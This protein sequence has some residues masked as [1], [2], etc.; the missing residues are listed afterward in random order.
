MSE[1]R[2]VNVVDQL[3]A[4]I[5]YTRAEAER[6]MADADRSP[7]QLWHF[8][9][10]LQTVVA[11]LCRILSSLLAAPVNA[12]LLVRLPVETTPPEVQSQS[13]KTHLVAKWKGVSSDAA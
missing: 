5:A 13:I 7:E 9:D 1:V 3:L 4:L 11:E 8:R 12:K 6:D 10:T 2:E